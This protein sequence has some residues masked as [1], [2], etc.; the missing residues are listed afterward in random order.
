MKFTQIALVAANTKAYAST[1]LASSRIY[2]YRVRATNA[3]GNSPYSN[4]ASARTP[5]R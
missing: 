2:Y 4:T 1:G 3:A 5:R